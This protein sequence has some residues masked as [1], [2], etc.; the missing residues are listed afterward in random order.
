MEKQLL[1]AVFGLFLSRNGLVVKDQEVRGQVSTTFL[2][3]PSCGL[4]FDKKILV[5]AHFYLAL[6]QLDFL[7]S[8]FWGGN[9]F[10]DF[11][12]VLRATPK[13][14]KKTIRFPN[15]KFHAKSFEKEK[16]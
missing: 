14:Q 4:T 5:K 2:E 9:L 15:A 1:F 10:F 3:D 6:L 16:H 13:Q 12:P 11:G 8:F 7:F